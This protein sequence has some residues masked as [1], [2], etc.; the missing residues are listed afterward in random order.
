MKASPSSRSS[1][2]ALVLVLSFLALITVIVTAFFFS[3]SSQVAISDA[4]SASA[5]TAQLADSAVNVVMAQ[6]VDAT[7]GQST[8]SLLAW[9]SQPGMIRTYDT[10]SR[11]GYNYKLYSSDTMTVDASKGFVPD[12]LT[13]WKQP[14]N[15]EIYTDLNAP[16]IDAQGELVFP[17]V[18]PAADGTGSVNRPAD[19]AAPFKVD[20]F[21]ITSPPGYNP[22][23]NEGPNNNRAPMPAMWLYQLKDGTLVAPVAVDATQVR[24]P[25]ATAVNPITGRIAFWTDDESGKININTASEG[26][27]WD[28]PR[29]WTFED[30]GTLA[31]ANSLKDPGLAVCQPVRHEFQ[32]YP[33]HPATTLS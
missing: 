31:G 10:N 17:I 26:T 5:T 11:P 23:T 16:G 28:T 6:I 4:T 12:D 8:K 29:A 1:G 21:S 15:R 20:G 24:V 32:R 9:A 22:S 19:K 18:D 25:G 30:F 14:Q 3:V 27:Y 7:K 2:V 13:S 33:G